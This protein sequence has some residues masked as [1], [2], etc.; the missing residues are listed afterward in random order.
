MKKLY[1]K[2]SVK[3]SEGVHEVISVIGFDVTIKIND[4]SYLFTLEEVDEFCDSKGLT[5]QNKKS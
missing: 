2:I 1:A 4:L 3:Y 5:F